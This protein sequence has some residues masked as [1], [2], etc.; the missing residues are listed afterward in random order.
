[1]TLKE[2][3]EAHDNLFPRNTPL[4]IP[5]LREL[6]LGGIQISFERKVWR[7]PRTKNEEPLTIPLTP[8]AIRI[9]LDRK[10]NKSEY[11]FPGEGKA[12]HLIEF[13]RIWNKIIA[14]AEIK[15]LRLHDL[16][17]TLGSWQAITGSSTII[18]GRSLGH[19]PQQATAIYA[20]LNLDPVRASVEKAT[21]A[22]FKAARVRTKRS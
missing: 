16:R 7:I 14:S 5:P 12:G 1:V 4:K 9:L 10:N 3:I 21:K 20:R 8:E 13:R 22:M 18:I 2:Q 6:A 15:D 17:R 19:K 11:V